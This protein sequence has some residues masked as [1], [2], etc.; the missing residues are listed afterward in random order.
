MQGVLVEEVMNPRPIAVRADDSVAGIFATF[1]ETHLLGFPVIDESQKLC[2]IVTLQDMEKAHQGGSIRNLKVKDVATADPV[3]VFP[4]EPVWAAINKMTPRD[5][6]RLPV[7]A[8][9]DEQRLVGLISRSEILRAYEVGLMRK[10]HAQFLRDRMAL[11]Q[12]TGVEFMEM[13]VTDSYGYNGKP[14]AQIKLPCHTTVVSVERAGIVL[15]PDGKTTILPHDRITL[16]S[17]SE[18]A[19]EVKKVFAPT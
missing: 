7:I 3:T 10:R 11:R 12:V 13:T 6:A 16:L 1:Q 15:I 5:Y 2:G 18:A 9:G 17:R 19:A 4:D 8:R 14:L